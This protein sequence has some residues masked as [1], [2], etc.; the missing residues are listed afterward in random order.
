VPQEIGEFA[1]AQAGADMMVGL[2]CQRCD[3]PIDMGDFRKRSCYVRVG[4]FR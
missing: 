1:F 4:T 2:A 3:G